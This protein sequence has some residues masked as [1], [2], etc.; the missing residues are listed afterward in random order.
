MLE[1]ITTSDAY[2]VT[3]AKGIITRDMVTGE[4]E[5]H[6][7]DAVVLATGGYGHVYFLSTNAMGS[8]V[9]AAWRAHRTGA[10]MANPCYPKSEERR[11]GKACG[12]TCG[13]RWE[14]YNSK[15]TKRQITNNTTTT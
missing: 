12:R 11:V 10:S 3:R 2:G 6:L 8:N 9:T 5:T 4:I 14:T 13:S 7:A 15:Q 1:L